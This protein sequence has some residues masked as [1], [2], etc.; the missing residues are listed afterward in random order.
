MFV[1]VLLSKL[2]LYMKYRANLRELNALTD[3]QLS[4]IGLN[5]GNIEFVARKLAFQ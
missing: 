2:R 5:R 1:T 3:T 4:D